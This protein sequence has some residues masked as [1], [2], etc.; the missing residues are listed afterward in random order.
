MQRL[1][2]KS[3][4]SVCC[5]CVEVMEA[6]VDREEQESGDTV[7]EGLVGEIN[8]IHQKIIRET[9]TNIRTHPLHSRAVSH[10]CHMLHDSCMVST[11]GGGRMG[12]KLCL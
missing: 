8:K 6:A 10:L 7:Q 4:A 3:L 11:V 5:E 1:S 9:G 12:N 2:V